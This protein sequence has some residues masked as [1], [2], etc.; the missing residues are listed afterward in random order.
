MGLIS[1]HHYIID[2]TEGLS[3]CDSLGGRKRIKGDCGR[4]AL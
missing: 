4:N 1:I 3:M 2:F